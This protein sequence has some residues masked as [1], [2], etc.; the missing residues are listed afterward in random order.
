M[1]RG[2]KIGV[3][4]DTHEDDV[5]AIPHIVRQFKKREV[6]I[7]VHCGDIIPEHVLLLKKL[8][9]DIPVI[10]ALVQGQTE[11]SLYNLQRPEN[12]KFTRHGERFVELPDGTWIYVGHK[13]PMDFLRQTEEKFNETLADLRMEQDGLR[14]VFGGHSHIQTL[15][16]GHMVSLINPG[17]VSGAI[18]HSYEYATVDTRNNE[19]VF[20]RIL[21]TRDDRE[22]WSLGVISD[23]LDVSHRDNTFWSKLAKE[24]KNRDVKDI[25][26]CG[27]IDLDDI[28]RP[29]LA[30]F[31][32][33]YAIR[34]DQRRKYQELKK[35]EGKIPGNW[36]LIGEGCENPDNGNIVDV[37]GYRFYVQL[38]L[39]LELMKI[40]ELG[41]D[42]LATAI[43]RK[44]P[45]TKVLL[46]GFT[47][48]ALFVE[49]EHVTT[50]NPGD[51]NKGR[52]YAVIC[53]PRNECTFGYVP[54]DPLPQLA[55][56]DK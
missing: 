43:C 46:C 9:G 24:F 35:I 7:V 51:A 13:R 38:D 33:N 16:Q 48:E 34:S 47:R 29:E 23:T 14:W 41:M 49:G 40:S 22:T 52:R 53:Y 10:C 31:T 17:A 37:R 27:N 2:I 28:G 4:S 11:D 1:K 26:H 50:I 8:L 18:S 6:E 44:Y 54:V 25:I 12:W 21:P 45:E 56:T 3:L 15:K 42:S 19:V 32:V 5:G 30:D 39:G 55:D 36:K 20:C